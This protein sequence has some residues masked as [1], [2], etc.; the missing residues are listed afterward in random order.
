MDAGRAV[1]FASPYELLTQSKTNV[2]YDM[3]KQMGNSTFESL[4]VVA[5][6]AYEEK[7][8]LKNKDV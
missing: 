5:Q 4:L 7:S 6:K 1:E 3:V 2:F 8:P